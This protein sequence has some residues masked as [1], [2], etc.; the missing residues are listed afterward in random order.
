MTDSSVEDELF[1]NNDADEEYFNQPMDSQ[2]Q[3]APP[4]VKSPNFK[5]FASE[6]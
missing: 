1:D 4:F 5:S 6:H 2:L 3:H